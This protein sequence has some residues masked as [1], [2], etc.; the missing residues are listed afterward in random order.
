MSMQVQHEHAVRGRSISEEEPYILSPL[1][2]L[3]LNTSPS[4]A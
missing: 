2:T 4:D 1:G 3:Q